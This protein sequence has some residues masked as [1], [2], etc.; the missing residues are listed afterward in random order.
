MIPPESESA[1]S[2]ISQQA[3]LFDP[4]FREAAGTE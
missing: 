4:I 2:W 1:R 3:A